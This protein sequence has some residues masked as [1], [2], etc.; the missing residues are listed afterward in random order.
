YPAAANLVIYNVENKSQRFLPL[1]G[2]GRL[3][4]LCWSSDRSLIAVA[5]KGEGH[6]TVTIFDGNT[7]RKRKEFRVDE[8]T[9]KAIISLA[10]HHDGKY[11]ITQSG[12]PDW[13]LHLWN[14]DQGRIMCRIRFN[15]IPNIDIREVSFN[16]YGKSAIQ[17]C[18]IGRNLCRIFKYTEGTL[19]PLTSQ[20]NEQK[21]YHCHAWLSAERIVVGTDESRLVIYD[22]GEVVTEIN[23]ASPLKDSSSD[24]RNF[25]NVIKASSTGFMCGSSNGLLAIYQKSDGSVPY[26]QTKIINVGN[27]LISGIAIAPSEDSLVCSCANN[28]I[29]AIHSIQF[30]S[31]GSY[32]YRLGLD[33]C[34]RKAFLAT[35]SSDYS[36]RIWNYLENTLEVAKIFES[37]P[38]CLSL[39]PSGL[40]LLVAFSDSLTLLTLLLDDMRPYWE[41]EVIECREC[42]FSNGGQYFAYV[43]ET[44]IT[45]K[46]TWTFQTIASLR[47]H[48]TNVTSIQWSMDDSKLLSVSIEGMLYCW[49]LQTE[50]KQWQHMTEGA[51]HLSA[52]FSPDNTT[53]Y[54]VG[55]DMT[56]RELRDGKITREIPM[57]TACSQI[58]VSKNGELIFLGKMHLIVL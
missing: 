14:W 44:V 46:S 31:Q 9:S 6:P 39:H 41:H 40:Y 34:I 51:A 55:S 53:L 20:K 25:V 3:S 38:F 35:C 26:K 29:M 15:T 4:S 43:Q 33:L 56:L 27:A 42:R 52:V 36:V 10:F 23:C 2:E 1:P 16:P 57:Q 54:A 58:M 21:N 47:G 19:K 18:V 12:E 30:N 32:M 49:D 8:T 5:E 45:I 11:L 28:K 50:T 24:S 37:E 17:V 13:M 7:F 48:S 22:N